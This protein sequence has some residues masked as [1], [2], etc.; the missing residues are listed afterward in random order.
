MGLRGVVEVECEEPTQIYQEVSG[1][2]QKAGGGH[3]PPTWERGLDITLLLVRRTLTRQRR[4][5][6]KESVEMF[7]EQGLRIRA[8]D[9]LMRLIHGEVEAPEI[10]EAWTRLATYSVS[11]LMLRKHFWSLPLG[12]QRGPGRPPKLSRENGLTEAG[13]K[14]KIDPGIKQEEAP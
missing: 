1:M 4:T 7:G 5:Y 11:A 12:A 14:G 8:S 2:T 10:D 9:E 3:L 6:G 13:N